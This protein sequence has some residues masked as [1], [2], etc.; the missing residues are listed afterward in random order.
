MAKLDVDFTDPTICQFDNNSPETLGWPVN[1]G[2]VPYSFK[3]YQFPQGV[4]HGTGP[5]WDAYLNEL[6]S[7]GLLIHPGGF[8]VAGTWGAENRDNTN[9]PGNPSFHACG[10]ALDVNAPWNPNNTPRNDGG[11]FTMPESAISIARTYGMLCGGEWNDW[12]HTE[13]HLTPKGVALVLSA[14]GHAYTAPN[15]KPPYPLPNGFYFGPLSGPEQSISGDAPSGSDA[16][17]R[18][19][20]K[21]IQNVIGVAVDGLYGP[22]TISIVKRWQGN[23]GLTA[24]GLTGP[25]TWSKMGL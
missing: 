18:P 5:I 8:G 2:Y 22:T 14:L 17:Y 6:L 9:D 13:L 23:H 24:D 7:V 19:Y 12:M 10:R 16:K 20:I 3:G 11:Q 21:M 15:S 1:T 4:Y 25:V